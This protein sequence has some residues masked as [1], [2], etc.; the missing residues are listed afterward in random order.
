M[1]G[2]V[3]ASGRWLSCC[4]SLL[5][6]YI[7]LDP[8]SRRSSTHTSIAIRSA[9]SQCDIPAS[10]CLMYIFNPLQPPPHLYLM[11]PHAGRSRH[12]S[13]DLDCKL[14]KFN[15]R[16]ASS[17]WRR[18]RVLALYLECAIHCSAHF[19]RLTLETCGSSFQCGFGCKA[20]G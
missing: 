1:A 7:A 9:L 4:V 14:N 12:S 13:R 20:A 6:L 16:C 8:A 15:T 3:T 2:C 11:Q 5:A 18:R 19:A 10:S 17:S